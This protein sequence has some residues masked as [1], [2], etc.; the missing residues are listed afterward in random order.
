MKSNF[1][2][3]LAKPILALAP[4]AGYTESP[5]RR[6][7]KEIEPSVVL[8]SELVSAE[9]MRRGS[10]KT[11]RLAS[12]AP[13][14]KKY[15]CI[16]LFGSDKEAFIEA[17]KIVQ[18]MGADGIDLNFGCPSPKVVGSGHGSALL[19]NPCR[20]AEMIEALVKAVDIPV[21]VKM[22]LGFYNDENLVQTA[23]DFESAGI[24]RIAIHGRTSTQ[25]YRGEA[26][27]E[28]IYE[29][30]DQV[31]IPV[32]GNGDVT[33]AAIAIKKLK[34]LDGIMIGR[35]AMR[36]PWI[37]AQCRA[38][39][40]G[41]PIPE[42]PP[43]EEQLNLFRRHAK[44]AIEMKNEHWAMLEMRKHFAHFVRGIRGAAIYRD[45]L[46]KVEKYE[47]LEAIFDEILENQ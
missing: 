8:T 10:E 27:W 12:F 35:A 1:W 34:N 21:S 17:G 43:L 30:K 26:A 47:E 2:A 5:F 46:I 7:V 19:K 23:K 37:F 16:Q 36:N 33:S 15:Y 41:E 44:L 14:E 42:K 18:D 6:L 31:N 32:L 9:A 4:M 45:R 22:R 24:T 39:F 25:K 29:V 11:M 38:A 28:K 3:S 20:S 40:N 13:E